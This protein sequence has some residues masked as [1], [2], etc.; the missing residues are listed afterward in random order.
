MNVRKSNILLAAVVG[1]A[2]TGLVTH[3]FIVD[4]PEGNE[5]AIPNPQQPA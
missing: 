5:S 1:T 4:Y 3:R 2:L